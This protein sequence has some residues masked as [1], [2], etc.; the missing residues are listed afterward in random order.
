MQVFDIREKGELLEQAGEYI[1]KQW[2]SDSNY[3]FYKDCIEQSCLTKNDVPRFF[4]A[5]EDNKIIGCYALLRSDLNSRQDLTPWFACLF[6]EPEYRG[7]KIGSLLQKH[8]LEQS[9]AKG[10]KKLYLC[11]ELTNYYE[12]NNWKYI[13]SGF[14]LNDE[15]TRIYERDLN[16]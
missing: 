11:T 12:K 3:H 7:K 10:Y 13:G 4:I 5:V 1:W 2:G 15:K 14:L 16:T 8:A 6:V 9:K